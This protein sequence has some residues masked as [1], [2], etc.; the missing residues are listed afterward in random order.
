MSY[1]ISRITEILS[2]ARLGSLGGHK[3]GFKSIHAITNLLA[4]RVSNSGE[5]F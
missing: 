4:A 3:T 5:I 2:L 1:I